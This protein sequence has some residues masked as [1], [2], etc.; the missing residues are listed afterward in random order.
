MIPSAQRII[1]S[2]FLIASKFSIFAITGIYG[3]LHSLKNDL[4]SRIHSA[5]LTNE[6]AI[7]STPCSTPNFRSSRSLSVIAGR[8]IATFGTLTPFFSPSSPP[9]TISQLMLFPFLSFT[10]S[11]IRPSSIRIV[12][13]ALTSSTRPLY[14]IETI[15]LSPTI[16]SVVRVNVSPA[17][18]CTFF[19]SFNTP[20]RISG[21][22]VSRRIAIGLFSSSRIF[23]NISIRPFCSS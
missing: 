18:S 17:S 6:A 2:I 5:F 13:P 9:L 1:S 14:V 16:S 8:R 15:L 20:V 23:F 4:I 3:A 12:L 7:K 21:P 11:S 19:P 22:F 10:F